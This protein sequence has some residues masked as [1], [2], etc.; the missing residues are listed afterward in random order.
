MA[1]QPRLPH[2]QVGKL[3]RRVRLRQ[4]HFIAKHGQKQFTDSEAMQMC[5]EDP[6]YSKRDL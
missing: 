3:Q 4:N 1:L 5:G 2:L 6:D